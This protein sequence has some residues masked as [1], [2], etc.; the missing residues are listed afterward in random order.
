M[1]PRAPIALVRAHLILP[2]IQT[3]IVLRIEARKWL[4][5]GI[6]G[7]SVLP[8]MRQRYAADAMAADRAAR[9]R[10]DNIPSRFETRCDGRIAAV[11]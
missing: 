11:C 4:I 8:Y 7:R 9:T 2:L 5:N 6:M 10:H 3:L 1:R